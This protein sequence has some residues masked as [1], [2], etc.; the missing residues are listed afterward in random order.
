MEPLLKKY[1]TQS[2]ILIHSEYDNVGKSLKKLLPQLLY[3]TGVGQRIRMLMLGSI[4]LEGVASLDGDFLVSPIKEHGVSSLSGEL[5]NELIHRKK[6]FILGPLM[7]IHENEQAIKF[8]ATGYLTV[9]PKD[10]INKF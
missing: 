10:L 6:I 5:K 3:G 4:G 9:Y 2:N 7:S 1:A 8:G